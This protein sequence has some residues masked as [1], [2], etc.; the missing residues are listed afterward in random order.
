MRCFCSWAPPQS[1]R[2]PDV[3]H[4]MNEP[5]PS[6]FFAILLLP[7]M[8][9][10]ANQR[11]KTGEAWKPACCMLWLAHFLSRYR[12]RASWRS[13]VREAEMEGR[14][15]LSIW[16]GQEASLTQPRLPLV[17][18]QRRKHLAKVHLYTCSVNSLSSLTI[19]VCMLL[20]PS[21]NY[22]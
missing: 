16:Q 10:N 14:L 6:P 21:S 9:L 11:T 5:G 4:V 12:P 13:W 7:C 17:R 15:L 8:I 1:S 22:S 3:I 2:S 20:L 18:T 19:S